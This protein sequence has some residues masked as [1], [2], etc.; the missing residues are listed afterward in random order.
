MTTKLKKYC[1]VLLLCAARRRLFAYML[2]N[3]AIPNDWEKIQIK[4][5]YH[6]HNYL[7]GHAGG[8]VSDYAA[9]AVRC[10]M[11]IL[12]ISDHCTVFTNSYD[13]YMTAFDLEKEYLPQFEKAKSL[14]GDRLTIK[15]GV[16][17]EHVDDAEAYYRLLKSKVDY[18]VLGQHI[19]L[20]GKSGY[21]YNSFIDGTDDKSV[22]AYFDN[23]C[24][25]IDSGN[26]A[27]VAHPD[28][29]FYS[30]PKITHGMIASMERAVKLAAEKG[31]ALELNANGI[32]YH[33]FRYPTEELVAL[34]KK[35]NAR[36]VVSSD[37]HDPK[38]LCD[39]YMRAL[40]AYAKN[41]GLNVV[42]EIL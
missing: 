30:R 1:F 24:A 42:D 7:C 15:C 8:T 18:L 5:N 39:K 22:A 12:G 29:I 19:F 11:R 20:R 2:K 31:V 3:F 34:C 13:S 38:S 4:S 25:G 27:L 21:V 32:R 28:L 6:T 14:Y 40:Y 23:V 35:H 16:E 10:G 9:E 37:A 26:F 36:V 41:E 33:G 17:I